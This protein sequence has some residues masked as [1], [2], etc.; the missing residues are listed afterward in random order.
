MI[1][2]L[3]VVVLLA[4]VAA[5]LLTAAR[6]VGSRADADRRLRAV[7]EQLGAVAAH[8]GV[9]E[10]DHS[11][12]VVALVD[13]GRLVEAIRAHRRRTGAGLAEAKRYVDEIAARR[14]S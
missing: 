14:R 9:P 6:V 10:P 1:E 4:L 8:L 7:E 13:E 12:E 5:V 3:L 2:V 11:S